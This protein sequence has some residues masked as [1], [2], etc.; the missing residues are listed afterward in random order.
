MSV[1]LINL[2]SYQALRSQTLAIHEIWLLVFTRPL[3]ALFKRYRTLL[4]ARWSHV[5]F[6]AQAEPQVFESG[7]GVFAVLRTAT[8][9]RDWVLCLHDVTA[10]GGRENQNG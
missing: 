10:N 7:S 4:K 3:T 9:G 5:A 8:T 2:Q 1:R 6:S